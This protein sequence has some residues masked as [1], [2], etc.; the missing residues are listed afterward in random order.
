MSHSQSDSWER[1]HSA[2]EKLAVLDS[3]YAHKVIKLLV[4]LCHRLDVQ[5][6]AEGIEMPDEARLHSY[7]DAGLPLC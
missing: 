2:C 6:I 7:L 1:Y 3:A 4:R 5:V